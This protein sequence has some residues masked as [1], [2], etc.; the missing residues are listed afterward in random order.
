MPHKIQVWQCSFCTK[1]RKT[2]VSINRHEEICFSNPDRKILEGQLAIF[3]TM[4]RE[5]I[6]VDSFDV[7]D[8]EWI[9][10]DWEPS[11]ELSDKYKWWPR[12]EDGYIDIGYV[13][14]E[15]E[16]QKIKG[17]EPPHFAPGFTWRDEIIPKPVVFEKQ[18]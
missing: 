14:A 18:G 8:S 15:G 3:G 1:Y 17:Y 11:K 12:D 2:K 10:P 5:L 13:Y 16:W 9:E 4:P 7:P 6:I